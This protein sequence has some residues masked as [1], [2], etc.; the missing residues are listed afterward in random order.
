MPEPEESCITPPLVMDTC[1]AISGD[2]TYS[3]A[4]S[5]STLRNISNIGQVDPKRSQKINLKIRH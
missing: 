2:A 3:R 1:N 4:F 5:Y